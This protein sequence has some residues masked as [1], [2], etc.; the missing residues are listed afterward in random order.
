M[1]TI[2]SQTGALNSENSTLLDRTT[3][4]NGPIIRTCPYCT[5][6]FS[7][8]F[9][10]HRNAEDSYSPPTWTFSRDALSPIKQYGRATRTRTRM[11]IETENTGRRIGRGGRVRGMRVGRFSRAGMAL[12]GRY[13]V[14]RQPLSLPLFL[15]LSSLSLLDRWL[16]RSVAQPWSCS[17]RTSMSTRWTRSPGRRLRCQEERFFQNVHHLNYNEF[18]FCELDCI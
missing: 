11:M 13:F 18:T 5:L 16:R 3:L 8:W 10:F 15:S 14:L 7:A 4:R 17:H 12:T 6:Y 2:L 1:N 9:G